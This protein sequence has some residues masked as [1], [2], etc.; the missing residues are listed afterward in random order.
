[1]RALLNVKTTTE[2]T[3]LIRDR[4]LTKEERKALIKEAEEERRQEATLT[5]TAAL[6]AKRFK[7]LLNNNALTG[8]DP[9]LAVACHP[10]P[11][12]AIAFS[13]LP[14]AVIAFAAMRREA[15][16]CARGA[17]PG[18]QGAERVCLVPKGM[19]RCTLGSCD[20]RTVWLSIH[21]TLCHRMLP[22][23]SAQL[24]LACRAGFP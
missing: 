24:R 17:Q 15:A 7:K 11:A 16:R 10:T 2:L 22:E 9:A 1:M 20:A 14:C 12:E 3:F 4:D 23:N 6:R 19:T 5:I 13:C 8:N 18:G 21:R